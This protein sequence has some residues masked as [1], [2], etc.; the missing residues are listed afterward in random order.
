MKE[1]AL[2]SCGSGYCFGDK[3]KDTR[4][5]SF[6]SKEQGLDILMGMF[7]AE[8]IEVKNV[9]RLIDEIFI[10]P[11]FP[12]IENH[13]GVDVIGNEAGVLILSKI[14]RHA[15]ESVSEM[16]KSSDSKM[17]MFIYKNKGKASNITEQIDPQL[18]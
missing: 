2:F 1:Y 5:E 12:I 4:N 16:I 15:L 17:L 14:L 6:F 11:D 13:N 9:I 7:F 3:I 8:K 18:N 10:I